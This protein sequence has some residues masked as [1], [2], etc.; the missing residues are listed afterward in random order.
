MN[1]HSAVNSSAPIKGQ[2]PA[3]RFPRPRPWNESRKLNAFRSRRPG[4]N[5]ISRLAFAMAIRAGFLNAVRI[6]PA[7]FIVSSMKCSEQIQEHSRKTS[8]TGNERSRWIS[9]PVTEEVEL[10]PG[11]FTVPANALVTEGPFSPR[12]GLPAGHRNLAWEGVNTSGVTTV[13]CLGPASAGT[14]NDCPMPLYLSNPC[15][16]RQPNGSRPCDARHRSRIAGTR[17]PNPSRSRSPTCPP[18]D[19]EP[20]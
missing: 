12:T 4:D 5:L 11:R 7:T 3:Q 19:R 9:V 1:A 2:Y 13:D 17:Y 20:W 8:R 18:R 6:S 10:L 14:R 16:L 15:S